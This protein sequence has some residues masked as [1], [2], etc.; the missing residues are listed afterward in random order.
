MEVLKQPPS[1]AYKNVI[2]GI[3]LISRQK[4]EQGEKEL[5]SALASN[6]LNDNEKA[7]CCYSLAEYYYDSKNYNEAQKYFEM[8]SKT[9]PTTEKHIVPYSYFSIGKIM[10]Q[11]ED[12]EKAKNYFNIAK[13]YENYFSMDRLQ[14]SV[15]LYMKKIK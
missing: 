9:K 3:N 6:S 15:K 2:M 14:D 7:E 13:T 12:F 4:Y 8:A 1:P 10:I 5:L 11:K